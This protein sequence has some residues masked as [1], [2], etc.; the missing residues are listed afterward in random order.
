MLLAYIKLYHNRPFHPTNTGK[1][2]ILEVRR[3]E[4]KLGLFALYG[5]PLLFLS[6]DIVG[7][8]LFQDISLS[9]RKKRSKKNVS[10]VPIIGDDRIAKAGIFAILGNIFKKYSFY[11]KNLLF[12]ATVFALVVKTIGIT[13]ISDIFTDLIYFKVYGI[14]TVS[15]V[16]LYFLLTLYLIQKYIDK[17]FNI[18]IAL[19]NIL[20]D[21]LYEIKEVA[22]SKDKVLIKETIKDTYVQIGIYLTLIIF[23]ILVF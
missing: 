23:T 3:R 13:H 16:L 6:R 14:I 8:S 10:E 19:P 20:K 7:I 12:M 17:P 21:W 1:A 4:I 15:C 22:H 11:F 9:S 5:I 18:P 2:R